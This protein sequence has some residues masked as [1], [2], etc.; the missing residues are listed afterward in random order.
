MKFLEKLLIKWI[1]L[2]EDGWIEHDEN[3]KYLIWVDRGYM[4]R[5]PQVH[6]LKIS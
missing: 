5:K 2:F 1:M 4:V 6:V 3:G